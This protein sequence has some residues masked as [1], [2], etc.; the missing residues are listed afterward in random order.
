MLLEIFYLFLKLDGIIK[1]FD[2]YQHAGADIS[3]NWN[4]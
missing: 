3:F 1:P 4:I 2:V